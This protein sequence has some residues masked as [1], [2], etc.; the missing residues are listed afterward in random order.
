MSSNMLWLNTKDFVKGAIVAILTGIGTILTSELQTGTIS[1][2]KV[3]IAALVAF[4]A[5]LTKNLLTDH[6]DKF[7]GKI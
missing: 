4:L 6:N 5:Y 7:I 2:K 3:G 1:L